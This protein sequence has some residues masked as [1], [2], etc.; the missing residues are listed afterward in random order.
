MVVKNENN[1]LIPTRTIMGWRTY[2]DYRKL[3]KV[4]HEDHFPL[5]LIDKML[6]RLAK[7]SYCCY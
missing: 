2:I 4:T 1:E 3:N 7:N 6:D 5:S